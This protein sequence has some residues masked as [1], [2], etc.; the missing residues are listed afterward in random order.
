MREK[1]LNRYLYSGI[2][3]SH[4]NSRLKVLGRT[5]LG[6]CKSSLDLRV[7]SHQHL[8]SKKQTKKYKHT[9]N[10]SFH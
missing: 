7:F 5:G 2:G 3:I 10:K 1:N 8:S 6:P 9:E 4:P